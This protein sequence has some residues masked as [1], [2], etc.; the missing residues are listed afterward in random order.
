[1]EF[2][3]DEE[4]IGKWD[5]FCNL[6]SLEEFDCEKNKILMKKALKKYILC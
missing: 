2:V 1:M 4:V 6:T 3:N 5:F